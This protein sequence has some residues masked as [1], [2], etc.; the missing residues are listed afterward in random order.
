M[1]DDIKYDIEKIKRWFHGNGSGGVFQRL[2]ILEGSCSRL[3]EKVKIVNN[4]ISLAHKAAEKAHEA[5]QKIEHERD[6]H[7]AWRR[8]ATWA[9]GIVSTL[10]ALAGSVAAS[11]ILS[12]LNKL[13]E[14]GS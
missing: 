13:A 6:Q 7:A 3:E 12:V 5:A 9:F 10:F 14:G 4:D 1:D 2:S 8:G 11:R